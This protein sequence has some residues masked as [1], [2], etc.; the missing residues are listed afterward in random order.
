MRINVNTSRHW[1]EEFLYSLEPNKTIFTRS[2]SQLNLPT[3]IHNFAVNAMYYFTD[4]SHRKIRP[5]V[6]AGGGVAIFQPTAAAVTFA[7]NPLGANLPGFRTS[8]EI[9][10]NAGVG[11]KM[12][13]GQSTGFRMDF[14]G[15]VTRNPSFGL[16]RSSSDPSATVFPATGSME[17]FEASAGFYFRLKE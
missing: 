15:F 2:T 8:P 1:G 17:S 7:N 13:L 14:R 16:P 5:F 12:K 10:F 3:W 9:A 11:Y 4:D 6:T